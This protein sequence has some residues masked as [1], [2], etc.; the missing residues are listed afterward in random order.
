MSKLR[1]LYVSHEISPFLE[2]SKVA[3]Y[4]RQLPES[5]QERGMEIRILV[6]KFGCINERKS[7]LHE[8]V[9]LS[10]INI[11][12]G[13]EEKPLIIKVASIPTAK[14]QVYFIDNDDYFHRKTSLHD[15]DDKF[16]VDNDERSIFFCKGVLET[17]KK[18][19]WA[20]DIIHCNDWMTALI[21]M[22]LKTHYKKEPIF[23]N[24]K[25]IFTVF[26]N[27]FPHKFDKKIT[28][29]ARMSEMTDEQLA[30]LA[31]GDYEGFIRTGIQYADHVFKA[32]ENYHIAH[33]GIFEEF[34]SQK[35]LEYAPSENNTEFYYNFYNEFAGIDELVA[36]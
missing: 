33:D 3:D 13:E 4:V 9:R 25:S 35:S 8:V 31:N 23:K 10:G 24:S 30:P 20:P 17:V 15:K 36:G 18:L 5:M 34:A 22:Y 19:G 7:R 2:T 12:M 29:R 6:P 27:Y 32:Q 11:T 1:I 16:H 14:L 28:T 21:P 26:D